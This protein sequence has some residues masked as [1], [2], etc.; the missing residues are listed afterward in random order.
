MRG[1]F[2]IQ[3]YSIFYRKVLVSYLTDALVCS[4]GELRLV[5]GANPLEGRIE[6]CIGNIWGTVCD[7]YW[8]YKE[9][10]VVCR[11]LG[12]SPTGTNFVL[13]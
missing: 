9:A 13:F 5:G 6:L 2:I 8:G 10:S 7:D 1:D 3:H 4:S 11:Q 12:F